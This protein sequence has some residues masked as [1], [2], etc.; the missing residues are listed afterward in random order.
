LANTA[1]PGVIEPYNKPPSIHA[2]E[3][4]RP[5]AGDDER[6][7]GFEEEEESPPAGDDERTPSF[8][9]EE[10]ARNDSGD[11]TTESPGGDGETETGDGYLDGSGSRANFHSDDSDSDAIPGN[12]GLGPKGSSEMVLELDASN[13]PEELWRGG[14]DTIPATVYRTIRAKGFGWISIV[15][16]PEGTDL[17]AVA[18]AVHEGHL[19][20]IVNGPGGAEF[21]DGQANSGGKDSL[22]Y[23]RDRVSYEADP[24]PLEILRRQNSSD[25]IAFVLGSEVGHRSSAIRYATDEF[26]FNHRSA[27]TATAALLLLPGLKFFRTSDLYTCNQLLE[28]LALKAVSK[29]V[30]SVPTV[31]QR[32]GCVPVVAWKYTRGSEHVLVT[33][34]F[35]NFHAVAD[36]IC[37]DAPDDV[38]EHGNIPVDEI[39]AKSL[40]MRV[41]SRMRTDGLTVLLYEYEIQV[42]KY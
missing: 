15:N 23:G 25:F 41:P 38:D 18:K 40:F 32:P 42:F 19:K 13:I 2:E 7:R 10:E 17:A 11:Q 12:C 8:Q 9:E 22:V 6:T 35:T 5:D 20:L 26:Q 4:E 30:F 28:V 16:V 27:A 3:E 24:V 31:R 34:N 37:E 1:P 36:V 33:V 29:G 39:L 14:I 21:S